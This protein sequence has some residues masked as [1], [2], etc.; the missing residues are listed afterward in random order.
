[1]QNDNSKLKIL[2]FDPG[3]VACGW[4][5]IESD[6][7]KNC[8]LVEYGVIDSGKEALIGDRLAKI[9]DACSN[10][11]EGLKPDVVAVEELFFFKNAKTVIGV[12]QA[13][14]V[15]IAA[16]R[17]KHITIYEYTPLQVKQAI[18]GYGGADK[19][20]IQKMVQVLL[21]LNAIPKP[22]DAADAL[23]TA[24]TCA[25]SQQSFL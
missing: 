5:L 16:A 1:M 4:G 10:L 3:T 25:H 13:R 9:F 7:Q 12:A 15:V 21:K 2:G 24:I 20:Q 14:G 22:D 11:L 17:K 6:N 18:T 8:N 23:A 19:S